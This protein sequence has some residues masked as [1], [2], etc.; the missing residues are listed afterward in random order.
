VQSAQQVAA[1]DPAMQ[2]QRDAQDQQVRKQQ[3]AGMSMSVW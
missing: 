2:M 3:N 1:P